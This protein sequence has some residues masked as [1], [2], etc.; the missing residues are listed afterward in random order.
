MLTD[1]SDW[2]ES[3][4][5]HCLSQFKISDNS[6][7]YLL[8]VAVGSPQNTYGEPHM[9]FFSLFSAVVIL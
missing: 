3:C 6:T 2:V 7:K 9:N 1:E 4:V 8:E 5:Y